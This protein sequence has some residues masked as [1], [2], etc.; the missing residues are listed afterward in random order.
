MNKQSGKA[1]RIALVFPP[2]MPPTSPPLG[3][4]G[5]KSYLESA[6]NVEVR[7]FDLNLAYFEQAFG[8]LHD[9][10]IRMKIKKMDVETTA[11]K[12]AAARNFFL[13]KDGV[14]KFFD[15]TEYNE[16]SGTYAAFSSVLNGLFDSFA[17]R[18]LVGVPTPPL[19]GRFFDEL[20][21]PVRAFRPDLIGFSILFS[22]QLFF[23]LA[24]AKLLG[25]VLQ[26]ERSPA[27]PPTAREAPQ[28]VFGGATFSV[29]P[30]P[31][32]L[33]AGPVPVYLG[34]EPGEVDIS[35]LIDYLIVGEGE[36]GLEA[37]TRSCA[38]PGG[39]TPGIPARLWRDDTDQGI[40]GLLHFKDGKVVRNPPEGVFALK[41]LPAPDFSDFPLDQYHSPI[42]VLPYLSSRGCPWRRCAFCTHQKTYLDYREE[43][44]ATSAE[45]LSALQ[46]KYGV[47]HFCLVDEMVHPRRME[48]IAAHI[49]QKGAQVRFA[50]YAKPSGFSPEVLEKAHKAGLRLLMWGLESASQR[51]LD[52][53]C[54]GTDAGEIVTVLESARK[55]GVWNLLFVIFGFP[56]ETRGEWA[57]TLDFIEALRDSIHALSRSRFILLEGSDVFVNPQHYGIKRI[58]DRP[59]RDPVSIAYDYEVSEGLT[60]EEVSVM[61][62]EVLARL[63]DIG[64][65]PWFG[66]FREH[67]LLFASK[68]K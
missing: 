14:G 34:N 9:G 52:L 4:A 36:R 32:R 28:I 35:R 12:A 50:A 31:G 54:K 45:R 49:I 29:M 26:P 5:L 66:Q 59:K 57:S 42:P 3:I 44:A 16:H 65:S 60:E 46:E 67:M 17:R 25:E 7:N 24:L 2:A 18:S 55:A 61:F 23:A 56:T 51:I 39:R 37:L 1:L 15:L 30:D 21:E 58:I 10:R 43:D 33:L 53:M 64:R 11:R 38:V 48:K 62:R 47:N 6:A 13:G 68:E 40:P 22:Q 63:K 8:W 41:A 20:I 27:E 19:A